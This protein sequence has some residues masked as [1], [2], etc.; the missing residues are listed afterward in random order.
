MIETELKSFAV[1]DFVVDFDERSELVAVRHRSAPVGPYLGGLRVLELSVDGRPTPW[2][3]GETV[4]DS[5]EVER[6]A[7]ADGLASVVLRHSFGAAWRTRLVLRNISSTTWTGRVALALQPGSGYRAWSLSVG[8]DST[9]ALLPAALE[10]PILVAQSSSGSAVTVTEDGFEVGPIPLDP[11][12]SFVAAWD[13]HAAASPRVL[14]DRLPG[15]LPWVL[16]APVGEEIWLPADRDTAVLIPDDLELLDDHGHRTVF[17]D[18]PGRRRVELR[19]ARGSTVLELAWVPAVSDFLAAA[20]E[21]ILTGPRGPSGV[22]G[23]A[24]LPAALVLQWATRQTGFAAAVEADDAL[25]LFT[26]RLDHSPSETGR[27]SALEISYLAGEY[28]RL[29]DPD[30]LEA[31]DRRMS[32]MTAVSPGLGLAMMR[33]R[34]A[35]ILAG[36]RPPR[37]TVGRTAGPLGLDPDSSASAAAAALEYALATETPDR[38]TS[39]ETLAWVYRVGIELRAGLP[40]RV[41]ASLPTEQLSHC[42]AVLRLLPD[43]VYPYWTETFGLSISTVTDARALELV[44]RLRGAPVTAAHAWLALSS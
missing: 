25:D 33:S 36:R 28:D 20:A 6:T 23:L 34:L 10:S 41:P 15:E 38:V 30:L 29:G 8:R 39:E 14:A 1:R 43:T 17:A 16:T 27:S 44:D 4:V 31:C 42:L 22:V 7:T 3:T 26:A 9:Y 12:F 18:R 21:Q 40:G 32:A 35:S 2:S 37:P 24:D 5:D 19:S 11:G 13:W